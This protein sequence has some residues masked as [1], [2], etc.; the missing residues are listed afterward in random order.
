VAEKGA[1][2]HK[3]AET[4]A[5]TTIAFS[6]QTGAPMSYPEIRIVGPAEV[7]EALTSEGD[8]RGDVAF[9]NDINR[10]LA[11]FEESPLPLRALAEIEP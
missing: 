1:A 9:Q 4:K 6:G 7:R 3:Q 11:W 5:G 10:L 8:I 2:G